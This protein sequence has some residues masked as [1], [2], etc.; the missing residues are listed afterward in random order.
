MAAAGRCRLL[1]RVCQLLLRRRRDNDGGGGDKDQAGPGLDGQHLAHIVRQLKGQRLLHTQNLSDLGALISISN[2]RL[3]SVKTRFEGV[4][5]L[6]L[7]VSDSP[8]DVF[9]DNCISWLRALQH[10]IQSQ[11]PQPTVELA[12]WV[13]RDLLRYSAQLPELARE[14]AMNH[15]PSLVA[16]LLTLKPECQLAAMDGMKTCMTCYP[17]ACGSL[18]GKLAACF[19]GKLDS[20]SPQVQE[21]ACQCYVLLPSLGAGF[22]QGLKYTESWGQQL[23]CLLTTLHSLAG[24]M[25]AET[26]TDPVCYEG[27]GVDLPLPLLSDADPFLVLRLRQ[28]FSALSKCLS[29][30]LGSDFPVPVKIP[31]QDVLNLVC[32]VLNI[33]PR[34]MVR[35]R[36]LPSSPLRALGFAAATGALPTVQV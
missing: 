7:L 8:T 15:I 21:L 9:Q 33:S 31:V 20:A 29:L 2:T 1:E 10:V 25:Y 28:R 32:R 22:A 16:S 13:L 19:L 3:T 26:E 17:R 14:V 18:R 34:S 35:P 6:A 12:V 5:L 11:D 27:P 30:I 36:L 23:H 24:E 4:C